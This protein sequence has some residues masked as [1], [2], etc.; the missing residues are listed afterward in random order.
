MCGKDFELD[1][2]IFNDW[3]RVSV[4]RVVFTGRRD[5]RGPRE[6]PGRHLGRLPAQHDVERHYGTYC[7]YSNFK[8]YAL[9]IKLYI[10]P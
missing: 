8:Q 5:G 7:G 9:Q 10:K 4:W 1:G 2:V 3:G 6:R